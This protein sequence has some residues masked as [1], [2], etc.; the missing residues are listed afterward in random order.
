M[1]S[2]RTLPL[3]LGAAALLSHVL[4][5]P[6][7][8]GPVRAGVGPVAVQAATVAADA[9]TRARERGARESRFPTRR[10]TGVPASQR[11]RPYRGPCTITRPGT[12]LVGRLVRCDLRVLAPRVVVRRSL[13]HGTVSSG[14]DRSGRSSFTLARSTVDVSPGGSRMATGVGE[15]RFRVLRSEVR[16][17]NRGINCWHRCLVR[18]S[19]VHGQDTDRTGVWHE[20]GI[21]M[22]TRGRIIGNRIACDAPTVPPDAGCSAPLTGYGDFG[23]VRDNL[24][25]RNLLVATTGGTCAYGGSSGGKPYSRQ[26]ARIRFVHNVFQRGRTGRCGYWAPVLDFDRRAP[27]NQFTGNRWTDGRRVRP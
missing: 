26:A 23:P 14:T 3:A 10:S 4:A 11:L 16:G 8:A 12:V 17:G 1:F 7:L 18:D 25:R 22:G 21:R 15:V 6:A 20:S 27:G 24:I 5:A 19:W 13:V 9:P 2:R